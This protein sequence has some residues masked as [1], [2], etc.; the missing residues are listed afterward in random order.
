MNNNRWEVV[1]DA[2]D[3]NEETVSANTLFADLIEGFDALAAGRVETTLAARAEDGSSVTF[4]N[5]QTDELYLMVSRLPVASSELSAAGIKVDY[6]AQGK[7]VG[8]AIGQASSR[9]ADVPRLATFD[10]AAA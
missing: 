8:F 7:V 9:L 1:P 6:D 4:Y 2:H 10:R 5:A 3:E